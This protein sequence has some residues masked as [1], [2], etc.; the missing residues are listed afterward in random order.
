[1][2]GNKHWLKKIKWFDSRDDVTVKGESGKPS[3][4]I[5]NERLAVVVRNFKEE[6]S[7]FET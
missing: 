5:G 4:V 7:E 1:M 6:L 3:P 2:T